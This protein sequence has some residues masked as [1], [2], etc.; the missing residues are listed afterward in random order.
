MPSVLV[1]RA[2]HQSDRLSQRLRDA[3]M[4]PVVVPVI[5]MIAP[6]DGGA[7]L[8]SALKKNHRYDWIA[9][10]SSNAVAAV[11]S[12]ESIPEGVKCAAIGPGTAEALRQLGVEPLLIPAVSTA[13][14]LV[15]AFGS[16]PP[17]RILLPLA[18][19]AQ[20]TLMDGL[21]AAGWKVSAVQAYQTIP[22]I[23]SAEELLSARGCTAVAFTSS[24]SVSSWVSVAGLFD[25]PQ[26][27][28]SIGPQTS[29][30]ARDVGLFV[31]AEANPHT[32]DGLVAATKSVLMT[33]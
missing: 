9:F 4:E 12:L 1:V 13:E 24:S 7:A 23:P 30:T 11:A 19:G 31:R 8:R 33:N 25:T 3:G 28:V 14:G 5:E 21:R 32:L 27:V 29:L 22:R 2:A 26:V 10:T 20:P 6:A 17:S 16:V 18:A 15:A